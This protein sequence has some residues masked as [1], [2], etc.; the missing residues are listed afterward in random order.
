MTWDK[1]PFLMPN[2]ACH[3]CHESLIMELLIPLISLEGPVWIS[4]CCELMKVL[5]KLFLMDSQQPVTTT[6][7]KKKGP[8][9]CSLSK[10]C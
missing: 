6:K 1:F 10:L 2:Q 9:S 3:F 8:Q 5:M 7:K 4:T